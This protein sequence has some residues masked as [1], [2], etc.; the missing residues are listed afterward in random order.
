MARRARQTG[1]WSWPD[2]DFDSVCV[3]ARRP[4]KNYCGFRAHLSRVWIRL[5]DVTKC[6][7]CKSEIVF[8]IEL[9]LGSPS[10]RAVLFHLHLAATFL[11]STR[12]V[13]IGAGMVDDLSGLVI[14]CTGRR[15]P[16]VLRSGT[17]TVSTALAISL[18]G[19]NRRSRV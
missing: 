1:S 5:A 9:D 19:Q 15:A 7:A 18:G 10:G 3:G 11:H 13:R 14:G 4:G 12:D 8:A 2:H 6:D 17:P 16:F